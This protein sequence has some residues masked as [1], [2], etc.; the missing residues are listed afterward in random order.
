LRI[1]TRIY[2]A[3]F[4]SPGVK[5]TGSVK[6]SIPSMGFVLFPSLLVC[7]HGVVVFE[8]LTEVYPQNPP[9]GGHSVLL[10]V[11]PQ[12]EAVPHQA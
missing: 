11:H 6:H 8:P 3:P 7:H 9:S 5:D 4:V 2:V 10:V 12:Q 1:E